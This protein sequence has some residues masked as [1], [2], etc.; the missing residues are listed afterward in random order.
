MTK[1]W[2]T[3]AWVVAALIS[4]GVCAVYFV[5]M[6]AF[7]HLGT[8]PVSYFNL[9]GDSFIHGHTDLIAPPSTVDL[10]QYHDRWY[11]PFPPLPALLM[12]PGLLIWGVERFNVGAFVG[13]EG[14]AAAAMVFLILRVVWWHWPRPV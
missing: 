5:T 10:A 12:I 9:L 8:S 6:L 4:A 13:I 3:N 11:V 1:Q 2:R 7:G 14:S